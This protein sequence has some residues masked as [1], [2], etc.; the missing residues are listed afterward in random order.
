[1]VVKIISADNIPVEFGKNE[2][3][4]IPYVTNI[5]EDI[6][7]V[8]YEELPII[9]INARELIIIKE[10]LE[11]QSTHG[12]PFKCKSKEITKLGN[13]I[14]YIPIHDQNLWEKKEPYYDYLKSL[15]A[16]ECV[17]AFITA[18]YLACY[19]LQYGIA[20]NIGERHLNSDPEIKKSIKEH[21]SEHLLDCYLQMCINNK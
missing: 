16:E 6:D 8:T 19:D 10:L 15:T 11:L 17:K 3:Q 14:V 20:Y 9:G 12:L 7:D 2:V 13:D 5:I 21:F 18:G 1:M 4:R